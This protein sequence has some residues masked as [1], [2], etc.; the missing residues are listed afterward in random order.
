M[1]KLFESFYKFLSKNDEDNVNNIL[2][3]LEENKIEYS[4]DEF[5]TKV[6]T[7]DGYEYTLYEPIFN[8]KSGELQLRYVNSQMHKLDYSKRFGEAQRGVGKSFFGNL[9]ITNKDN[10]IRTIWIKDYEITE[11]SDIV[12]VDTNEI[13]KDYHRKWEVIKNY[14]SSA[15]G[16]IQHRIYARDCEI[17][18]VPSKAP[19]NVAKKFLQKYCFYGDRPATV[20]LGLY[21]KK[22][23]CGLKA[24]TLLMMDTFGHNF[25][26]NKG[27]ETPT[28]EVIRVA[29][30]I[31]VQVLGGSSKLLRYFLE[32]YPSLHNSTKN[33][34]YVVDRVVFYVD[35]DH[36]DGKSLVTLGYDYVGWDTAGFHNFATADINIPKLKV[37]KGQ[38]FQRK[39]MIHKTIM[40]YMGKGDIVSIGTSGTIVYELH[41]EKY[42]EKIKNNS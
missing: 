3:F 31:G 12:D 5:I 10:G 38:I 36:N 1:N 4:T 7:Q 16:I 8:L 21:L 17:K 9:S 23:K 33:E 18:I 19:N 2:S 6:H 14:I 34:D 13:I 35:A 40:E 28:V 39:P 25:Y 29:T 22:D 32:N 30:K 27:K 41:R 37:S 42:L 15:V 24:G 11:C 20:S 26:G